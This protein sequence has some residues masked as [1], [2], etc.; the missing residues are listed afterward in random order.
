VIAEWGKANAWKVLQEN[1]RAQNGSVAI[2]FRIPLLS[3]VQVRAHGA[4]D[5]AAR[6]A[7][8]SRT[9]GYVTLLEGAQDDSDTSAN[10]WPC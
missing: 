2:L 1:K 8:C 3:L 5:N 6:V 10:E 9:R 7:C 4:A